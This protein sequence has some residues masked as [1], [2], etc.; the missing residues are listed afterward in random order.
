[1]PNTTPP[2]RPGRD[3]VIEAIVQAGG[4]RWRTISLSRLWRFANGDETALPVPA[5]HDEQPEGGR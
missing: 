1:M 4:L 3:L 5:P 2:K